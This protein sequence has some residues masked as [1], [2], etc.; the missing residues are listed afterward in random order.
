[1]VVDMISKKEKKT[2]GIYKT[3]QTKMSQMFLQDNNTS[4]TQVMNAKF[5]SIQGISNKRTSTKK[6]VLND[7][8]HRKNKKH[9]KVLA[10]CGINYDNPL[11]P[12][13]IATRC[14]DFINKQKQLAAQQA[15]TAAFQQGQQIAVRQTPVWIQSSGTSTALA[16]VAVTQEPTLVSL[17]NSQPDNSQNQ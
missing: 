10:G 12:V 17:F 4:F 6:P 7:R 8:P 5:D 15:V 2:S 16:A 9:A 14:A 11:S 13:E 1:M 3:H